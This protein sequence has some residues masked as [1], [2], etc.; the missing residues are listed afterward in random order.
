MGNSLSTVLSCVARVVAIP[1]HA[2]SAFT[3][4]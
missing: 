4:P 3:L 1:N 2:S